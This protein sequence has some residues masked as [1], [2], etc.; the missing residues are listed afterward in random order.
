MYLELIHGVQW[1]TRISNSRIKLKPLKM[2]QFTV[3][4]VFNIHI[5]NLIKYDY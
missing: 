3:K 1:M 2:S 5:Y 4:F